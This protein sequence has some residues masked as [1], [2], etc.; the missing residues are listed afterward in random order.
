MSHLSQ[1]EREAYTATFLELDLD[2]NG[3]LDMHEFELMFHKLGFTY[4]KAI[5]DVSLKCPYI[6]SVCF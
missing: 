4:P 1:S 6:V 5:T 2:G 3:S